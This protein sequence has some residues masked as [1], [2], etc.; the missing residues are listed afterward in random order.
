ML[1]LTQ[2]KV[3]MC[4]E[5]E[6]EASPMGKGWQCSCGWHGTKS[7]LLWG[8]HA[9]DL[10]AIREV[11]L[12]RAQVAFVRKWAACQAGLAKIPIEEVRDMIATLDVYDKQGE[13]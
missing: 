11:K 5:C 9:P 1:K 8:Y 12:L 10:D 4:P 13:Q 2:A 7:K 3:P 6:A